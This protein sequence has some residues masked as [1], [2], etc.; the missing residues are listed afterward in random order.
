MRLFVTVAAAYPLLSLLGYGLHRA[1]HQKWMGRLHASHMK[2]HRE[3]Y[4]VGDLH[5]DVYRSAGKHNTVWLFMPFFGV[6]L[7]ALGAAN[8]LG[9]LP[10]LHV[11]VIVALTVARG[12]VDNAI[13][14]SF[15][16]RGHWM[17]VLAPRAYAQAQLLHFHHHDQMQ[18]NFGIWS[19]FW[20]RLFGTLVPCG[21]NT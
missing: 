2:H 14:D 19:F 4:P 3:L 15:H 5:S 6:E 21:K 16:V 11:V 10:V 7:L 17:S 20:D 1:M 8:L 9:L 13:H 12:V 18:S